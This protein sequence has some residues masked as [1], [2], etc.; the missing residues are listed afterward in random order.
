MV[1]HGP[2]ID[3]T[4][5]PWRT[6]RWLVLAP[7]ADDET[8]GA[9]ALITQMAKEG[10]LAGLVYLTDG[11][12]SHDV[13]NGRA[14]WLIT[15]RKR[16]AR[17]AVARLT[18]AQSRAPL[19][20]GWRDAFPPRGGD[21]QFKRSCRSLAAL[22]MRLRVDILATTAPQE[23]HCDHAAAAALARAVQTAAARPLIVAE[24]LVWG[25]PPSCRTHI[26]LVTR[27]MLA[28]AR[29]HALAAHRSQLTASHGAGFRLP[30]D[31]RAMSPRDILYI[32]K[33]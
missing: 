18:G 14:G 32:R 12:G 1:R 19:F 22:C 29:R 16:E 2:A 7:H 33:S 4:K 8:L 3:L 24:Y 13:A 17:H 15:T 10:R 11:S 31:K 25:L 6:K 30:M 20:L 27:P 5:R 21:R 26:S 9:G 23:P 28:G